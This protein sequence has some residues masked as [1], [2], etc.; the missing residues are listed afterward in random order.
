M[1]YCAA[2]QPVVVTG[3]L[4]EMCR[5][6]ASS[7]A[8]YSWRREMRVLVVESQPHVRAAL[9]FLLSQQSD[10]QCV[11]CIG[12][13]PNL[14]AKLAILAADVIVLDWALPQHKAAH[15]LSVIHQ[16]PG[17]PRTVVLGSRPNAEQAAL[18]AGADA[19]VNKNDPPETVLRVVRS[20]SVEQ[21]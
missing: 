2:L 19:F 10:I 14:A 17:Q 8:H 18:A 21:R 6:Q 4:S 7:I 5:F 3:V 20:V 15:L 16:L 1:G 12:A 9:R 11:G 13:E